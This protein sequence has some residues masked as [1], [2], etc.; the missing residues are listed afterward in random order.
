[1]T[2]S[3]LFACVHREGH[4][5]PWLVYSYFSHNPFDTQSLKPTTIKC[6]AWC[7]H[8]WGDPGEVYDHLVGG[9]QFKH[10]SDA[11]MFMITWS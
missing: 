9:W 5:W 4:P 10:E 11:R 6:D 8:M 1:M 7:A 3:S 2:S